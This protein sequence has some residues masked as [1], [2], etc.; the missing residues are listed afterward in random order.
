MPRVLSETRIAAFRERLI[1]VAE[2][3]FA[4]H[5]FEAVTL[6]QIAQAL[7]VSPMTPYR[8]FADK[9]AILAAVRA[10][11]FDRHADALERAYA[12]AAPDRDTRARALLNAYVDFALANPEA[13]KLMFDIRQ[14]DEAS[15]PDLAR[16]G[17]RSRATM[18]LHL[19][20][21]RGRPASGAETDLLGH[22]FWA[23]IHGPLMLHFSG[24]LREGVDVRRLI[25]A[26]AA[27][28]SRGVS[29]SGG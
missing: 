16:A 2:R 19:R 24:M 15:Y 17:E 11:G 3:L 5:G 8:Y 25:D 12:A 13:Y 29:S 27:A 7:G 4:D 28:L 23:A 9:D 14:P 1:D 6:R 10:R 18:T 21:R 26:L 20:Q 22:M